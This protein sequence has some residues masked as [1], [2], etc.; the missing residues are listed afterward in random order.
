[1]KEKGFD[2]IPHPSSLIPSCPVG[3]DRRRSRRYTAV[4]S[5]TPRTGGPMRS[6]AV[7]LSLL[8]PPLV[9]L[10]AALVLLLLR[11]E[12][13]WYAAAAVP[14]GPE[15]ARGSDRFTRGFVD[16]L[17]GIKNGGEWGGD[18]TAA[19]ANAYLQEGFVE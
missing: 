7:F 10:L 14:P 17:S 15:R 5:V 16:M 8:L 6:R 1:M 12:P 19:D 4:A 13:A 18:F 2:F 3:V 9:L 11:H